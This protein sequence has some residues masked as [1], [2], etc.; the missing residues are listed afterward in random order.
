MQPFAEMCLG[1]LSLRGKI[2]VHVSKTVGSFI[3]NHR[4]P[5]KL[6]PS[7]ILKVSDQTQSLPLCD[8]NRRPGY[9]LA[10]TVEEAL[11]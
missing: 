8:R 9:L 2:F 1:F 10:Q 6:Q 4:A 7:R 5:A 11:K 3:Q